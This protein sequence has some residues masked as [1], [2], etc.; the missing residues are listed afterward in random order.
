MQIAIASG[1]KLGVTQEDIKP[2][3]HVM[4]FRINAEDPI[5]FLPTPGKL[6]EY[7]IPTEKGVRVDTGFQKGSVISP[8][9]DS[10]IAKVIVKGASREEVFHKSKQV[11]SSFSIKGVASTIPFHLWILEEEIFINSEHNIG[12]IDKLVEQGSVY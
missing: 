6:T 10:L 2:L 5:T 12:S 7:Q 11:L 1:E 9:Y 4:E 8:Y 3:G